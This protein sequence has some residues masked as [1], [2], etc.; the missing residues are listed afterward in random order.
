MKTHELRHDGRDPNL[1]LSVPIGRQL[2]AVSA[3]ICGSWGLVCLRVSVPVL[4]PTQC[5]Q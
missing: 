3:T 1:P 2:A 5:A 4:L